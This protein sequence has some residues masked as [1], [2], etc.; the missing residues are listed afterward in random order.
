VPPP[1]P[2]KG[3]Y[4]GAAV[5]SARSFARSHSE[6]DDPHNDNFDCVVVMTDPHNWFEALQVMMLLFLELMCGFR[7]RGAKERAEARLYVFLVSLRLCSLVCRGFSFFHTNTAPLHCVLNELPPPTTKTNGYHALHSSVHLDSNALRIQYYIR[8]LWT[9][10]SP[11][12]PT[13]RR[14][15]SLT[16]RAWCPCTSAT[17]TSSGRQP[18]LSPGSARALSDWPLRRCSGPATCSSR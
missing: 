11:R 4:G 6:P 7:R 17:P 16:R 10:L 12:R 8:P 2:T 18:T 9:W 13:R 1:P 14:P 3:D 5:G 15:W